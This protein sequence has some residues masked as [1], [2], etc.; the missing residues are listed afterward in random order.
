MTG[1]VLQRGL[2]FGK[3]FVGISVVPVSRAHVGA[4]VGI[5]GM[6]G[7]RALVVLDRAGELFSVVEQIAQLN[8]RVVVVG[9]FAH[10][11]KQRRR[12]LRQRGLHIGIRLGLVRIGALR[13]CGGG[14]G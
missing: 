4:H 13:R 6:Q 9:I 10:G 3:R 7:Q 1:T 14:R 2:Q 8:Q 12:G 5:L 11:I